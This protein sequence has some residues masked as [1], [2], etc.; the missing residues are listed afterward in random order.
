MNHQQML[1]PMLIGVGIL[2]ALAVAGVP[3]LAFA[4]LLILV[5]CPVMMFFMMRGMG[6][7]GGHGSGHDHSRATHQRDDDGL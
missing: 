7:S 2:A 1:K 5:A 3:V 6:H 4:P